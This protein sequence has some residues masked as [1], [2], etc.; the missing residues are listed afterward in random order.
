MAKLKALM[1]LTRRKF[2]KA[3]SYGKVAGLGAIGGSYGAF[4]STQAGHRRD[5]AKEGAVAGAVA[6][7][8]STIVFRRVRGRI[9]PMKV[10]KR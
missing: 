9:I 1:R 3:K 10:K 7:V 4:F 8:A 6:A 5:A 2:K